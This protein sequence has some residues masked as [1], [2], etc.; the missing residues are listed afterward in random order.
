[1]G[2]FSS[3]EINVNFR[4]LLLGQV[5]WVFANGPGDKGSFQGRVIPK[6]QM[7]YLLP[8]CLT[9]STIKYG[10]RVK[11][12]NP[13]KG[14]APFFTHRC[15]SKIKGSLWVTVDNGRQ[16]Y[17]SG[18]GVALFCTLRCSSYWK[19]NLQFTLDNGRYLDYLL[20]MA[21]SKR[22][23]IW[24]SHNI[25]SSWYISSTDSIDSLSLSLSLSLA[26]RS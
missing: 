22:P 25:S 13:G 2:E 6:T 4:C 9:L 24:I 17:L 8:S 23:S 15:S 12:S 14:I 3:C 21:Q 16:L 7:W 10:S 26:I 1:M 11:W 20:T 19:T 18:K 5:D